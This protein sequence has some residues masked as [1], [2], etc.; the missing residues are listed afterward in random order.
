MPAIVFGLISGG[1]GNKV[2][3]G[4]R[5]VLLLFVSALFREWQR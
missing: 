4:R 1:C 2:L 3:L 5:F